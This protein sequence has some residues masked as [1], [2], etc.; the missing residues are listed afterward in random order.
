MKNMATM[1]ISLPEELKQYAEKKAK[2]GDF[3]TPSDYVRSLIRDDKEASWDRL[4]KMLLQGLNSG[5]SIVDS[6]ES[7]QF[8]KT[9]AK[10]RLA[11]HADEKPAKK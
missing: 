4:E 10:R 8:L 1:S 7:R 6:K 11:E 3:S 9:E 5:E 2:G